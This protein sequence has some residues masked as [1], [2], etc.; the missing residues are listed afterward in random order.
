MNVKKIDCHLLVER[1]QYVNTIK[2]YRFKQQ[3]E[4]TLVIIFMFEKAIMSQ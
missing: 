2:I 1:K 4:F 3:R